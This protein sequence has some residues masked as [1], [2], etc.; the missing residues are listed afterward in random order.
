MQRAVADP[1]TTPLSP[2]DLQLSQAFN[3]DFAA[4]QQAA[5]RGN[6]VPLARIH[7]ATRAAYAA[8]VACAGD[9]TSA[10]RTGS[11]STTSPTGAPHYLDRAAANEYCQGCNNAAAA[12]YWMAFKDGAGQRLNGARHNY[13]LTFTA[14]QLPD[15]KRF[16]SL[17]AYTPGIIELI[18]NPADKYLVAR[19]TPGLVYNRGRL[20]HDLH[21]GDQA[22]KRTDREL[23]A[24]A[25]RSRSK[26][27]CGSTAPP[28]TPPPAPATSRQGSRSR[29]DRTAPT[30]RNNTGRDR[31]SRITPTHPERGPGWVAPAATAP[32]RHGPHRAH[33][34]ATRRSGMNE[35]PPL[36]IEEPLESIAD[37]TRPGTRWT[38][39]AQHDRRRSGTAPRA[40][41]RPRNDSPHINSLTKEQQT[42]QCA[43][44]SPLAR[45]ITLAALLLPGESGHLSRR[46][47][48]TP[49]PHE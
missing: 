3:R 9:R 35:P 10:R 43:E 8:I 42:Q 17:T 19:Y 23:A 32:P 14:N 22:R 26:S 7:A 40:P 11:T 27:R 30:G 6:P 20:A 37:E 28:A 16:W 5:R 36:K 49:G 24:G 1:G 13:T 48:R 12:G 34:I 18:R 15:A 45:A 33:L 44:P 4:A 31:T 38:G 47:E 21:V 46:D 39:P 25:P 2:S 41:P 29:A